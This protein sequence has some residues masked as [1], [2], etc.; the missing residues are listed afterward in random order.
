M[1]IR[2]RNGGE[3]QGYKRG[4]RCENW[5]CFRAR[6]NVRIWVGLGLVGLHKICEYIRQITSSFSYRFEH[7]IHVSKFVL[8]GPHRLFSLKCGGKFDTLGIAPV[9]GQFNLQMPD[10]LLS[11]F[12]FS[13][14]EGLYG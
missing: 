11:F 1:R 7:F 6:I 3:V 5:Y 10:L 13:L 14:F 12:N 9:F 8:F 2:V 4:D